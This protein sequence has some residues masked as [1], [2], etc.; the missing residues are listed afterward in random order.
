MVSPTSG[1]HHDCWPET[2]PAHDARAMAV[3]HSRTGCEVGGTTV[4]Y[5]E[6]YEDVFCRASV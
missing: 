1:K 6:E 2:A 4:E 5:N 3:R